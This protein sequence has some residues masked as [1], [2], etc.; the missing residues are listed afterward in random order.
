MDS[1]FNQRYEHHLSCSSIV[2]D[3]QPQSGAV[4]NQFQ[5][6]SMK[7]MN[8]SNADIQDEPIDMD[9]EE[10][11]S[12]VDESNKFDHQLD[13][14]FDE[15]MSFI[16]QK[17]HSTAAQMISART[18]KCARCRNHGLVSMLR[19][20]NF[21]RRMATL[22]VTFELQQTSLN[23]NNIGSQKALQVA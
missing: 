16:Q 3:Q 2:V 1:Q 6:D 9:D 15:K 11:I 22:T 4:N 18:P 8:S 17:Q 19:V 21:I 5:I 14:S 10:S 7:Q 23:L 13:P 20:S 12:I